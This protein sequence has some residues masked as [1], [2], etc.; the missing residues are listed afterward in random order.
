MPILKQEPLFDLIKGMN[1]AEKRNFKLYANRQGAKSDAKFVTL[2]D[3]I[4]SMEE[5][6]EVRIIKRCPVKKEQ[7]P[8]MKSHL[9]RQIL[10]SIRLLSVQHSVTIQIREMVDFARILYD[11]SLFRQSLKM[12]DKAKQMAL[13][14]KSYALALE[15]V[16]FEKR[17]EVLHMTR[18]A[19]DRAEKLTQQ[20]EA[21]STNITQINTLSSLS[22]QLYSLNL[23]L[24]YV[25]SDKDRKM[26]IGYFRERLNAFDSSKMDFH[27]KLYFNQAMMWYSYIQHD[28]VRCYRYAKSWVDMF[29]ENQS[30][31][32]TYYDHY[33]RA[34]S[35]LLD[36][37]FMT[38]QYNPMKKLIERIES[39]VGVVI[40]SNDNA[41]IMT[42]LCLLFA[43]INNCFMEGNFKE[44]VKLSG[45]VDRFIDER[46]EYLDQHYQMLLYYK[47]ACLYFG[48]AD[49]GRCIEYL[50][51]IIL[52][53]NPQFRRDLQCFARILHLIASYESGDDYS[54]DYQVRSVYLFVVKMNDMHAVQH[55]IIN[56]LRRLPRTYSHDFRGELIKLLE[57]LKPLERDPNERRPFFY[58]DIISWLESKITNTPIAEI[59]KRKFKSSR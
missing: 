14:T 4:D 10:V 29:D 50:D 6:D 1:K 35:R 51:K 33:I 54:L 9:Y 38:R 12:L 47:V 19:A 42:E 16:E 43:K 8:N 30:Y 57:Q 20:S 55:E 48:N 25:R 37:M 34:A 45:R 2:F 24:G 3:A 7:L 13:S 26:V 31:K 49:Y 52:V 39:E 18:S 44:G 56:F 28:F 17:V 22:I 53:R 21:I 59:I 40:P 27:E 46:G 32:S 15:V 36:V 23:Q 5:Y 58:L 41:Q 11:K